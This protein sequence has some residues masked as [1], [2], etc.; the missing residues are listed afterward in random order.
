MRNGS[1]LFE[2]Q[3]GALFLAVAGSVMQ[4]SVVVVVRGLNVSLGFHKG[5]CTLQ[6]AKAASKLQQM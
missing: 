3:L 5:L 6:L 2:Q 4:R 1:A